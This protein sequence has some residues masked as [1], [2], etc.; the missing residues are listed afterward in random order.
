MEKIPDHPTIQRMERTGYPYP[1]NFIAYCA[2][3]GRP[4]HEG[5]SYAWSY[6]LDTEVC[7]DC[8]TGDDE[9]MEGDDG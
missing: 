6:A 3:C 5:D 8:M 7:I 1:S 2:R 9:P 4:I